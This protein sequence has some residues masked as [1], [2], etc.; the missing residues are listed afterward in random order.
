MSIA[1]RQ[2]DIIKKE[3]NDILFKKGLFNI[4]KSFGVPHITGSY[5]LNLMSWRDLDIYL[6]VTNITGINFF[7]LG[8]KIASAFDPVKMSFRNE[9]IGKTKELPNGLYWGIYFGDERAGAWKIDIWAVEKNEC[10]RLLKYCTDLCEK[11]TPATSLEIL[12]IKSQC[13]KDP[14]YRRSFSSSDIYTAV[15]EK[16]ITGIEAFKEYLNTLK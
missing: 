10:E 1:T 15:L 2:N 11:L 6:E 5:A 8:S 3:A 14:R 9:M 7:E 12:T 16:N 4:L 13:W